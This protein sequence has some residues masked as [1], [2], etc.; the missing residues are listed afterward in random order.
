MDGLLLSLAESSPL[1]VVSLFAIWRMSVVM[2]ALSDALA[3]VSKQRADLQA[4]IVEHR[5][6]YA[7][8]S[9]KN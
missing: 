7:Q 4:D 6:N 9:Q 2:V 5:A 3:E 8:L 1:A